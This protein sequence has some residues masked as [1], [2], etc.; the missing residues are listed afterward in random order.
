MSKSILNITLAVAVTTI[1]WLSLGA[2]VAAENRLPDLLKGTGLKYAMQDDATAYL[3]LKGANGTHIVAVRLVKE[4]VVALSEIVAAAP[5]AVPAGLWKRT[6]E[7]NAGPWLSHVGYQDAKFYSVS[8]CALADMNSKL[9][10]VMVMQV[11]AMADE[12]QPQ[13][14][15]LLAVK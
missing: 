2:A 11:S 10:K 9:L 8:G 7:I 15:D 5:D 1:A 4:R 6:A 12:L 3:L 13:F 14:Q